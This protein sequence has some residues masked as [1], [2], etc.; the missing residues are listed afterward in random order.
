MA[1]DNAS[2]L[3]QATIGY[4]ALGQRQKSLAILARAPRSLLLELSRQPDVT[5]LRQD[6]RFQQLLTNTHQ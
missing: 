2:V 3:R 1:P 4:E 6:R 5:G